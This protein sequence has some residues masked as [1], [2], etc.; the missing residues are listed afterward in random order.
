MG[1]PLDRKPIHPLWI[2]FKFE[3]LGLFCYEC[4]ML[5]HDIKDCVDVEVQKLWRERVM[6][7]IHGSWLRSEVSEFQPGI[8]LDELENSDRSECIRLDE[9]GPLIPK[10]QTQ[11]PWITVVQLALDAW[12]DLENSELVDQSMNLV[13]AST[14]GDGELQRAE[15]R[16]VTVVGEIAESG[17]LDE[18]GADKVMS[19]HIGF[20]ISLVRLRARL[21]KSRFKS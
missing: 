12:K 10:T 11:S 1:F 3:K 4:G 9:A 21:L 5:G 13:E 16:E 19:F 8:D 18:T 20:V 14:A 15:R 2:Q 17:G 6:L 7:G